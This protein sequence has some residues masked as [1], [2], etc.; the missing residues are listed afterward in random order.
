MNISE[1]PTRIEGGET[2]SLVARLD[3]LDETPVLTL[4]DTP[5]ESDAES[6]VKPDPLIQALVDKLP[7]PDTIWSIDDRAKWLRTAAMAFNLIYRTDEGNE[8]DLKIE[9]PSG[10]KSVG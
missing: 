4:V 1:I 8:A 9:K 5:A 10:L 2:S 7:K 6:S 3:E